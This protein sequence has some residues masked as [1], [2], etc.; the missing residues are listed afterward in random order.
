[1]GTVPRLDG[2]ARHHRRREATP[3]N[4][5]APAT[6][7]MHHGRVRRQWDDYG[8]SRRVS[9]RLQSIAIRRELRAARSHARN[10]R[11][12]KF[13]SSSDP[14]TRPA[15]GHS[16]IAKTRV[17]VDNAVFGSAR[18]FARRIRSPP[19]SWLRSHMKS[20]SSASKTSWIGVAMAPHLSPPCKSPMISLFAF[21]SP[22]PESPGI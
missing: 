3:R 9:R 1:M 22:E 11:A 6:T 20:T 2:S 15:Y 14:S 21:M 5:P 12:W 13:A 16:C 8:L 18:R 7:K 4:H 17:R 19:G 10:V